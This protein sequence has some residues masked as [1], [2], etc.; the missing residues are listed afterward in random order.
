MDSTLIA[1]IFLYFFGVIIGFWAGWFLAKGR[2]MKTKTLAIV[3]I[4]IFLVI[5]DIMLILGPWRN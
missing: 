2:F 1:L 4:I 5:I 3:L